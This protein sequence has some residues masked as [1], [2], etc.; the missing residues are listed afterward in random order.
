MRISGL[1]AA[2]LCGI[3][4]ISAHNSNRE[5]LPHGMEGGGFGR[6][7]CHSDSKRVWG[8]RTCLREGEVLPIP[9]QYIIGLSM[10]V[11]AILFLALIIIIADSYF[12]CRKRH[13][14]HRESGTDMG[15]PPDMPQSP[16]HTPADLPSYFE[17][18]P[19]IFRP[20]SLPPQDAPSTSC[21]IAP[22]LSLYPAR[23]MVDPQ[24]DVH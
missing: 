3:D 6:E 21:E 23:R 20:I 17:A 14:G 2:M 13:R 16:L 12:Q 1:L 24:D 11:I 8:G 15:Q 4:V 5:G 19:T 18:V 10:G 7:S 9:S 22:L